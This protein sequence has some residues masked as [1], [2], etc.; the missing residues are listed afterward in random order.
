[1]VF[2]K[3]FC[4]GARFFFAPKFR[5][6]KIGAAFRLEMGQ[7]A[8]LHMLFIVFRPNS[9]VSASAKVFFLH[10]RYGA[11]FFFPPKFIFPQIVATFQLDM[12]Q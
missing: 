9:I 2:F 12:G 8:R 5:F 4:F 6:A 3:N 7:W 1:M 10:F 11:H